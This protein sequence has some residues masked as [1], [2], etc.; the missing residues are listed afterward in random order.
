MNINRKPIK[1]ELCDREMTMVLDFESAISY[2]E[3]MKESIFKGIQRISA[4]Q[5][6]MAFAYLLSC[7]LRDENDSPVGIDFIKKLDLTNSLEFFMEK[8]GELMENSAPQS[9]DNSKKKK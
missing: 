5:D 6:L 2:Q 3:A 1:V 9:K 8:L 7:V 4:D